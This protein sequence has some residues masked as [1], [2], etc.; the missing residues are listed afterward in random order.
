MSKGN[1][2]LKEIEA[3]E[4]LHIRL[5]LVQELLSITNS[6]GTTYFDVE[7]VVK[8]ILGIDDKKAVKKYKK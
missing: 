2:R 5:N 4:L 1:E 3:I 6:D 8:N 7:W